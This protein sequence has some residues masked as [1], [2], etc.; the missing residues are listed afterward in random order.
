VIRVGARRTSKIAEIFPVLSSR[1]P[2]LPPQLEQNLFS[3]TNGLAADARPW[4]PTA[5]LFRQTERGR[6]DIV[7]DRIAAALEEDIASRWRKRK[8]SAE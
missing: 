6:W 4:Y 3:L 8:A 5:R 2:H 7:F 1:H